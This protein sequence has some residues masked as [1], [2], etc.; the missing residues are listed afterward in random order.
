[1]SNRYVVTVTTSAVSA[2]W[3][4]FVSVTNNVTQRV[5]IIS[6]Q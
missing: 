4:S 2:R 5:T 3:W 6:P 1:M